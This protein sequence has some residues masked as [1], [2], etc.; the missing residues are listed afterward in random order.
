[1][2]KRADKKR[3]ID[4][5]AAELAKNPFATEREIAK[6]TGIAHSTVNATKKHLPEKSTKDDRIV[7]LT[8]Q[9]FNIMLLAGREISRRIEEEPKKLKVRDLNESARESAKRYQI[10]RGEVTDKKGGLR[11]GW[12]D[13]DNNS[14]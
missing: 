12:Q 11:I 2:T 14:I 13:E 7:A 5:V 4:K 10:F 1:M 8:D 9:D 6:K 3:N